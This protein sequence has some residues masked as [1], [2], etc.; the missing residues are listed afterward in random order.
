MHAHT[1]LGTLGRSRV[2]HLWSKRDGF[3][4]ETI[5]STMKKSRYQQIAANLS[6]APRGS[7][8]S[9][10]KI[11][12]LDSVLLAACRVAVGITQHFTVD[13]SMIKTLSKYCRWICYMPKKPIK[14]GAFHSIILLTHCHFCFHP[15]PVTALY[16]TFNQVLKYSV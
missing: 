16:N 6:F 8:G 3:G 1:L 12:W 9:W 11:G 10:A 7:E 13:E 5:S 4:D 15:S 2:A 14:R